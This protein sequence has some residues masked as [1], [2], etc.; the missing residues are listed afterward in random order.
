VPKQLCVCRVAVLS[1]AL[2]LCACGGGSSESDTSEPPLP[3]CSKVT[4]IS[5][6]GD[7]II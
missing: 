1:G 7:F 5:V 3:R 2:F 4:I 6:K